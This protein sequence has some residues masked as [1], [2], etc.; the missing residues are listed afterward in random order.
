MEDEKIVPDNED[1]EIEELIPDGDDLSAEELKAK[2]A[3]QQ[4]LLK[5]AIQTKKNW[6]TKYEE[7]SKSEKKELP[8][9]P[10]TGKD[11]VVARIGKLEMVESKRQFGYAKGLSPEET[12]YAFAFAKGMDKSPE[13]ILK[14]SFFQKGLDARRAEEQQSNATPRPSSRLPKIEGK[15][16]NEMT[17]E[18]RSKNWAKMNGAK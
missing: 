4:E 5:E 10:S 7:L 9:E 6:R 8:T 16:F 3:R 18:E 12:D 13:D 1:E 15:T 14:D 2:L 17:P 11:E